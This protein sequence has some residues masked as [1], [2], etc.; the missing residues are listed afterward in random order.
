V[1]AGP[2][3]TIHGVVRWRAWD[4]IMRLHE[5]FGIS[6]QGHTRSSCSIKLAGMAPKP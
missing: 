6:P 5:E 2:I 4:L 1:E 3:P